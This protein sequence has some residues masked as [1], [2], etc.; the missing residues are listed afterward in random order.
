MQLADAI[1]RVRRIGE[2]RTEKAQAYLAAA[3]E[4]EARALS[5]DEVL[6]SAQREFLT[7]LGVSAQNNAKVMADD[8]EALLLV[9]E[10]VAA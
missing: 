9:L 6:T 8:A 5:A 3:S 1:A 7:Q 4:Y 10:K 2:R